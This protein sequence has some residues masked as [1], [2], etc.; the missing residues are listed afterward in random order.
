MKK[1]TVVTGH[2]G[3]G[4]TNLSVNLAVKARSNASK[5]AAVVDLDIVNPYFRAADFRELFEKSGITFIA[6]DFANT[7]LD[8]PSL[9]FDLA[10]LAES[11]DNLIVDVGGD[12]AGAFA[13][14]RFS[15]E[16]NAYCDVEMLYV[17][18]QRR[19]L[20]Q[21][22]EEAVELM[23][24]IERAS[25][26]KHTAIVNNTNLGIETTAQIIEQSEGFALEVSRKTG[27]PIKF[28]ACSE[29]LCEQV[30]AKNILPIKIYVRPI[31]DK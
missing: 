14:G 22:A 17:I 1:I 19:F 20:T 9:Q 26:M 3:S 31:W 8:I 2:Y 12:D 5:N 28:T 21:T 6:P 15:G 23:Y 24:E 4:K 13:L 27:L 16:L 25:R 30:N 10:R 11:Y 18:N 7:N 29:E